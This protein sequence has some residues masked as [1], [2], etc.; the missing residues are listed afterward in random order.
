MKNKIF[1][2]VVAVVFVI[3]IIITATIG[4]KV[5]L[6]YGEGTSIAFKVENRIEISEIKD[7]AKEVWQKDYLVQKAEFFEDSAVIKVRGVSQEQLEK[8]CK[9]INEKY[10]EELEVDDLKVEHVSNVKI[11]T[12][13]EPYI[14]PIGLSLLIIVMY[15]AI[16]FKGIRQMVDLV[17]FIAIFEALVYSAYAIFRIP[18]SG[19]TM[20]IVAIVYF[21][22]VLGYTFK[23]EMNKELD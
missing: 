7:I 2:A 19:I 12:L 1:Y 9:L 14:A 4:L 13:V 18:V 11:R 16:R 3:A 22:T 23:C 8:L 15:Y 6:N 10:S 17:K 5:N 20:P 21:G